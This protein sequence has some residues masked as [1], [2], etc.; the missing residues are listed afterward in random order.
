M[1]V[2]G[3]EQSVIQGTLGKNHNVA[4]VDPSVTRLPLYLV[5]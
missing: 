2:E 5:G 1:H 3:S 4:N